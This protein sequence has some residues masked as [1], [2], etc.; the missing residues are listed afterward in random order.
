MELYKIEIMTTKR[1]PQ[2]VCD[3]YYLWLQVDTEFIFAKTT[4]PKPGCRFNKQENQ[5]KKWKWKK[6]F[7]STGLLLIH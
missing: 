6:V 5:N 4:L 7:Q 2:D 3:I 1:Q